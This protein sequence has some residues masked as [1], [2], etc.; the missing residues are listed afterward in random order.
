MDMDMDIDS[1]IK[2]L[3]LESEKRSVFALFDTALRCIDIART[4]LPKTPEPKIDIFEDN[5]SLQSEASEW[6]GEGYIRVST[7]LIKYFLN[8]KYIPLINFVKEF[9]IV[10]KDL[11]QE[12]GF[13]WTMCHEFT[14]I[15]RKHK[16]TWLEIESVKSTEGLE[17]KYLPALEMTERDF[18]RATEHDAD[19][20]AIAMVYRYL[21]SLIGREVSDLTVKKITFHSVFWG[22]RN[23]KGIDNSD[24]HNSYHERLYEIVIKLASLDIP[25]SDNLK[26][27]NEINVYLSA[28]SEL[29]Q[30]AV[31]CESL[32][33]QSVGVE[34]DSQA[35]WILWNSYIEK[36]GSP[37]LATLWTNASPWVELISGT[38]AYNKV[39]VFAKKAKLEKS[40]KAAQRKNVKKKRKAQSNARSKNR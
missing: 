35:M 32:Y 30:L 6:F 27:D 21:K 39:D 10:G 3:N 1:Y 20:C 13:A 24:T 5:A 28:V 9:Y 12:C 19:S 8:I 7:G 29:S 25:K 40:L 34:D 36:K 4:G 33:L 16:S 15:Y 22:L 2:D 14:H 38:P 26:F 11:V 18:D 23:L 31:H 17:G 37:K